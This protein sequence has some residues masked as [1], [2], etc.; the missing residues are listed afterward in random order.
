MS[1]TMKKARNGLLILG[2]AA[3][4]IALASCG[5]NNGSTASTPPVTPPPPAMKELDTAAVL[6]IVQTMTSDTTVPFQVDN[7]AVAVT[8]VGD[9]T[10][11]PISVNAM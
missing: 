1:S 3:S 5:G 7:A 2:T 6:A 8:P 9:E 4:C 10:G 11:T